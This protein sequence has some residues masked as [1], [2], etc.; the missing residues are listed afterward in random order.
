VH[1]HVVAGAPEGLARQAGH[2]HLDHLSI[3]VSWRGDEIVSDTGTGKYYSN[4]EWRNYA[5]SE[6][7]HSGVYS[8]GA[9]WGEIRNLF[10]ITEPTIGEI[11]ELENGI[12]ASTEHPSRGLFTREIQVVGT[13]IRIL[14][15]LGGRR[16]MVNFIFPKNVE[17]SF[18]G[19]KMIVE[20]DNWIFSRE[21]GDGEVRGNTFGDFDLM[22]KELKE[23]ECIISHGYG[24]F[25]VG[26]SYRISHRED[27]E[28]ETIIS[29]KLDK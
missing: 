17:I 21:I 8:E 23:G 11:G 7:A 2:R 26:K 28:I 4:E 5:R 13:E 6:V 10:E 12:I 27:E 18:E 20:G 25:D 24:L 19:G 9:S 1:V 22:K 14:D 3:A 29:L 15:K 16:P